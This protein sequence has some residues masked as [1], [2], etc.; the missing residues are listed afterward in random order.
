MTHYEVAFKLQHEKCPYNSF[1]KAY[2]AAVISHWC[3]WSRD[4]LEIAIRDLREAHVQNSIQELTDALGSKIIRRSYAGSNLQVVL[5]HC[6]CDTIPPPTLPVIERRNCL[7]MQPAIYTGGWEWYRVIA[8]SERDIA[9]LFRDLDG[10]C[11]VEVVSRRSVS[12]ES[13]RDTFLLSVATLFGGLTER[14]ADAL[15]TALDSGYYRM[16]RGATAGEIAERLGLPRTSFVDHLRKGENKVL[17]ALG[18]YLRLKP[19]EGGG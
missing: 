12:D 15:V 6:A 18:P 8:F 4:V 13:I 19:V 2:P 5:M 1:S 9:N 11:D 10:V 3:N 16:P 17:Q 14:Q 7:E